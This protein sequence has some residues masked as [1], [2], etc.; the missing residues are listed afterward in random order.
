MKKNAGIKI[1]PS[2]MCADF[3]DLAGHIRVME[4]RG[5]DFL[6]IDIM[7]GH[8]VPN[9]TLGP[10]FCR[11]LAEATTIPLDIHLMIEN[12]DDYIPTFAV[13]GTPA[14]YIHPETTLH[15]L[16]TLQLIRSS[17][18]KPGIAI[19]PAVPLEVIL[20]L[21]DYADFVCVMTVN[22]GYAGQ[23]LITQTIGKIGK[24]AGIV[25]MD[26]PH[27]QIEVDGNVSWNNIPVMIEAG[28]RILVAGSSSLFE[29]G[30][31]LSA[32]IE[33][34]YRLIGRS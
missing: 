2:M 11:R 9:F 31:D 29:P 30:S 12:P 16:R 8:Y 23:R 10:D 4:E 5:I 20:P 13:F 15:P 17:G 1:A 24:L 22:P 3:F 21:L 25:A 14:L 32:N 33:R 7:D 27:I 19:D 18:A 28:A 6:H 26:Y 34:L